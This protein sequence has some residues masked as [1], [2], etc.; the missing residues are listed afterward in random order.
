[1]LT[2]SYQ[3]VN[4]GLWKEKSLHLIY[5]RSLSS[6]T[7]TWRGETQSMPFI[8]IFVKHSNKSIITYWQLN[9]HDC[10]YSSNYSNQSWDLIECVDDTGVHTLLYADDTKF[11]KIVNNESGRTQLQKVIDN[12]STWSD[13]NRLKLNRSKTLHKK[14]KKTTSRRTITLRSTESLRLKQYETWWSH[15]TRH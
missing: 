5:W 14:K 9:L 6:F 3:S 13:A 1:M 11:C 4:T 10:Q 15:S 12:L 7:T 8:L 2:A